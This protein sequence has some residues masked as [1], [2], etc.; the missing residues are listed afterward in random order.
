[1]YSDLNLPTHAPP[2]KSWGALL[3]QP[4]VLPG[5][6]VQFS[7]LFCV[8]GLGCLVWFSSLK[9]VPILQRPPQNPSP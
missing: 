1:M 2:P 9:N 4:V 8:L 6:I 5:Q 3:V 7:T